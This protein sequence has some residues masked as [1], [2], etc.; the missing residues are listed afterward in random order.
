MT[1]LIDI[2]STITNFGEALL[3]WLNDDYGTNHTYNEITSYDWFEKT[4]TDPWLP[5]ELYDFWDTV[6]VN[7][8]AV[9]VIK[10]W[11]KEYKQEIYLV[12]ASHYTDTL[13]YK[14]RKT[15]KAFY[16][17]INESQ[18]IVA[19]NKSMIQGDVLID[20]CID[21]LN[22]FNGITVC[23]PQPWNTKYGG[24]RNNCWSK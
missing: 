14:I 12:T 16:G 23:Y 3:K 5:T 1:I 18:V 22:A 8:V 10:K 21:N 15:L 17:L 6:E 20:D 2:D 19:R 9:Y 13:G 11:I 24:Y 7:P 4:F